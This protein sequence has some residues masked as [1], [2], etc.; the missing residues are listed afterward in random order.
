[1]SPRVRCHSNTISI[2]LITNVLDPMAY[3]LWCM[4]YGL[5]GIEWVM[6]GSVG[7]EIWNWGGLYVK[8]NIVNLIPL[9]V[10]L[11]SLERKKF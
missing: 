7:M 10:F 9:S 3:N 1:M 8:D 5:L 6:A 2:Y 11:G 4:V